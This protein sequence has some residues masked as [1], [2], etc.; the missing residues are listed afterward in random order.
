MDGLWMCEGEAYLLPLLSV[1]Q[2]R[3]MGSDRRWSVEQ[4]LLHLQRAGS[5]G[6]VATAKVGS[7][8]AEGE[9]GNGKVCRSL[10]EERI[11]SSN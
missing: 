1:L 4:F 9:F 2:A 10:D 8:E 7:N 11:K 3:W 6:V 5:A